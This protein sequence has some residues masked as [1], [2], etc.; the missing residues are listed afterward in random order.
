MFRDC[1]HYSL[2][3]L[4]CSL[5][6][7]PLASLHGVAFSLCFPS[8]VLPH[9]AGQAG[10]GLCEPKNMAKQGDSD[11][12]TAKG[13]ES[14]NYYCPLV[15]FCNCSR[16]DPRAVSFNSGGPILSGPGF[17][18]RAARSGE[19][20]TPTTTDNSIHLEERHVYLADTLAMAKKNPFYPKPRRS[21]PHVWFC[22]RLAVRQL[23][24][25]P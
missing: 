21:T 2:V 7:E 20:E 11:F 8:G 22:C 19:P 3:V 18:G 23:A 14:L 24:D 15:S 12:K 4:F 1:L 6:L 17:L 5:A 25:A 13:S 16:V 9:G 10:E